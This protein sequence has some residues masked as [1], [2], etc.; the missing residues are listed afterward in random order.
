MAID[1]GTGTTVT[2]GSTAIALI[3]RNIDWSGVMREAID[4]S[5]LGTTGGRTFIPGDLYNPGELT[6]EG[7]LEQ[8]IIDEMVT[9]IGAAAETVTVTLPDTGTWA[10]SGFVKEME[11]SSP[12]EEEM[13]YTMTV[14]LTDEITA[15]PSA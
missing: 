15:T 10:A 11:F 14:Q 8:T 13:T 1:V 2:F 3:V 9:K 12:I 4:V 5:H 6:I 7:I